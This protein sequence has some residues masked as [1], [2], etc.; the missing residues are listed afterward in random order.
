MCHDCLN[1]IIDLLDDMEDADWPGVDVSEEQVGNFVP[2]PFGFPSGGMRVPEW[3]NEEFENLW[4]EFEKKMALDIL[5]GK[6]R[7]VPGVM[8]QL[9]VANPINEL[10]GFEIP[11][12]QAC[13]NFDDLADLEWVPLLRAVFLFVCVCTLLT[14]TFS[15]LRW[16]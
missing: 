7:P 4:G 1:R 15:V 6:M 13:I 11:E 3:V 2:P 8:D 16:R 10:G 14:S 5:L 9:C 12:F